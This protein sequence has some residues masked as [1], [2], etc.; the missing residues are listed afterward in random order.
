MS[1][2]C[3][4][5]RIALEFPVSEHALLKSGKGGRAKPTHLGPELGEVARRGLQRR[6]AELREER[7]DVEQD[8]HLDDPRP[9]HP[10]AVVRAEV[11]R[12]AGQ[13]RVV[14]GEEGAG[15]G[16]QEL[17]RPATRTPLGSA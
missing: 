1:A 12:Q 5:T 2:I 14:K 16:E 9:A 13:D 10:E 7:Q 11:H 6:P 8:K 4:A 3:V 17:C 15:R